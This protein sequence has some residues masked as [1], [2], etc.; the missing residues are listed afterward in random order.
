MICRCDRLGGYD[1]EST[2]G[3]RDGVGPNCDRPVPPI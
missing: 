3:N 2:K 1:R